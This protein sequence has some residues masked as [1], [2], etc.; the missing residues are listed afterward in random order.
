VPLI[1]VDLSSNAG[2]DSALR[3]LIPRAAALGA[4]GVWD[5]WLMVPERFAMVLPA[6][7][8]TRLDGVVVVGELTGGYLVSLNDDVAPMDQF[9]V[10]AAGSI[11]GGSDRVTGGLRLHGVWLEQPDD[12]DGLQTAVVPFVQGQVGESGFVHARFLLALD[13]PLGVARDD[14]DFAWGFFLGGARL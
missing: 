11:G 9:L 7:A 12:G 6:K 2:I 5:V 3:E 10:R 4:R 8:E 1:F 14:G 13:E